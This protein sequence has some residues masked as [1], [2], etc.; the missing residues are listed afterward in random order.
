MS[1][2]QSIPFSPSLLIANLFVL[3]E[4]QRLFH[5]LDQDVLASKMCHPQMGVPDTYLTLPN[6]K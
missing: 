3:S 5:T 4:P 1:K 6:V 2:N